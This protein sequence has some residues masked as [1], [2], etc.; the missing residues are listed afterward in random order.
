[1]EENY[2]YHNEDTLQ[3]IKGV[4]ETVIYKNSQNGFIVLQMVSDNDELTIATGNIGDVAVGEKLSLIGVFADNPKYGRQ[5]KARTAERMLPNTPYE[6][7]RYLASGVIEGVG[8]AL[9]KKLVER[10]GADTLNVIDSE[11]FRITDI[12]GV[13]PERAAHIGDEYR[14]ICNVKT[15]IEFLGQYKISPGAAISVWQKYEGDSIAQI[16]KNPY[17][18]CE[19]GIGLDFNV[20]DY[21]AR[22]YDIESYDPNRVRAVI[23]YILRE[24]ANNGHTC[25]PLEVLK[26]ISESRYDVGESCFEKALENGC[27]GPFSRL[28]FGTRTRVFLSEYYEAEKYIADKLSLML[29]LNIGQTK[30]YSKEIDGIEFAENIKY[31]GLQRQAIN[32]CLGNGIFIL[33]GGPGT[34]KT[35]TINAVIKLFKQQKKRLALAAPTGRAAK[36]MADLTG[37][38][39]K[40]IHRLLEVDA[41]KDNFMSF[42]RD[43][44]NPL[45]AD[46]IIIDEMSM[47]DALLFEALLRAMK[48]KCKLILVGDSNQLPSVGAGNVLKDLIAAGNIP[49]V[50]LKEIFRQAS[51]SLIITNAHK[52]VNGELP[53]LDIRDR[54][55][56]FMQAHSDSEISRLVLELAKTRLPAKYGFS[57]LEDIQILSP[58]RMGEAGTK[59]LNA[60]LQAQLNPPDKSKKQMR[61][62]DVVFRQGDKVMQ[63]KNNYDIDWLRDGHKGKGIFNGD[64]GIITDIS[65]KDSSLEINFDG[66]V[67]TCTSEMLNKIEH[68]FAIT[69]HKSQGSEYEA[70]IV[71]LTD[72]SN[73]LLYRNLLYTAVTR[74]KKIL[75]LIGRKEVVR[76]MVATVRKTA[77][78]SCI[79]GLLQ[80]LTIDS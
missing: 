55:F 61:F 23:A 14:K 30:D 31:E 56:F 22:E 25:L 62:F 70:V 28:S 12:K 3:T 41:E 33:T 24:N 13:T 26:N 79:K 39:T 63:T 15:I 32:G 18:L 76:E 72:I 53:E 2:Q 10:F 38:P 42:K 11:P 6:I 47:V 20:A 16:K 37:E 46:I 19:S 57:S 4:V 54:D 7:R 40:T 73:Q 35:T 77:R 52:I 60:A 59:G 50:E 43:E 80:Q 58:T 67:A 44:R 65:L 75:I 64:I 71:P 49:S 1:M 69:V 74:A 78:Y 45:S 8:P 17:I 36:R 66:R 34:G 21:I 9:A 5:F 51:E 48:S 27:H 29:K 68:A